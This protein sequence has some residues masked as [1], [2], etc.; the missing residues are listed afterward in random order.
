M[1]IRGKAYVAQLIVVVVLT[2]GVVLLLK[3]KGE[4]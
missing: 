2:A 3:D 4:G 1:T